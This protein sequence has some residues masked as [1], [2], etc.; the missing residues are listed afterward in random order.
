MPIAWTF[1][2]VPGYSCRATVTDW[3]PAL[4]VTGYSYSLGIPMGPWV[5][6]KSHGECP[7]LEV[8]GY[9]HSLGIPMGPWVF[10]YPRGVVPPSQ[11]QGIPRAWVSY[12]PCNHLQTACTQTHAT[13]PHA[14]DQPLLCTMRVSRSSCDSRCPLFDPRQRDI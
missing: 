10:L 6:L 9:F 13:L 14:Y 3:I 11:L 1:L 5:F 4:E 8:T 12:A 2:W 7:A